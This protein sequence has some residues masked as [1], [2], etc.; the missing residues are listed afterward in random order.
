MA[1]SI[2]QDI[3]NTFKEINNETK[4]AFKATKNRPQSIS[5]AAKKGTMQFAVITSRANSLADTTMVAKALERQYVSFIRV[6]ASLNATTHEDDID[7]YLKTL[8]QNFDIGDVSTTGRIGSILQSTKELEESFNR[9]HELNETVINADPNK[10]VVHYKDLPMYQRNN[11]FNQVGKLVKGPL[12]KT[13]KGIFTESEGLISEIFLT[14]SLENGTYEIVQSH[15]IPQS[16][17]F[18]KIDNTLANSYMKAV[19]IR[20]SKEYQY[21]FNETILN[22]LCTESTITINEAKARSGN[23]KSNSNSVP[24]S[25]K[26]RYNISSNKVKGDINNNLS[27]NVGV[28]M[29]MVGNMDVNLKKAPDKKPINRVIEL[30]DN[31]AKKANELVPTMVHLVTHFQKDDKIVRTE[32]YLIGVKTIIHPVSSESMIENLVKGVKRDRMF[33]HILKYTTGEVSFFKDLVL[34]LNDIKGE[35]KTKYR[36]SIWWTALRRRKERAKVLS[37]IRVNELLPNATIVVTSDELEYIRVNY[38]IDFNNI[39]TAKELM[40]AYYLLGFVIVDPSVETCKFLFD[41]DVDFREQSYS[42][43]E[44]ENSNKSKEIQNIMQILGKM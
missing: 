10:I 33:Q 28:S 26:V 35:I 32:E 24:V 1:E 39:N 22:D 12:Y 40:K 34:T 2:F 9:L 6:V 8:H 5:R 15:K 36:D 29:G 18:T 4:Q 43:L 19:Q 7:S 38:K 20:E 27:G 23:N 37:R 3:V 31:D 17:E 44:R 11:Y 14:E 42:S 30:S 13:S 41:G 16:F 25:R 21:P